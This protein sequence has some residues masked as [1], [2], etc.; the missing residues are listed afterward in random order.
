M[1]ADTLSRRG[2]IAG[3]GASRSVGP[4][5]DF[6]QPLPAA[7]PP[8]LTS[9]SDPSP[10]TG[11]GQEGEEERREAGE[12][13]AGGTRQDQPRRYAM[14]RPATSGQQP[15]QQQQQQ[16]HEQEFLHFFAEP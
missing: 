14:R 5:P 16:Q 11:G 8:L 6:L 2:A 4:V 3:S 12:R 13:E 10:L 1:A 15:E 9:L 7:G